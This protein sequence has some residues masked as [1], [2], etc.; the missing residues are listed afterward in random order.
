M[1]WLCTLKCAELGNR[2][3]LEESPTISS[4]VWELLIILSLIL[5][6]GFFSGAELAIISARRGQLRQRADEGHRAARLAL[7]LAENPN[8][9]L[10]TVQV[11]I[12]LVGTLT[13][14]FGGARVAGYLASWLRQ[15]NSPWI[16]HYAEPLS[17][18]VVVIALT[19]FTVLLG[20]LVPKR[21]AL[22]QA[23]LL[24]PLVAVPMD[25]LA[26][27]GR[28]AVWLLGFSTDVVLRLIGMHQHAEP[29][30]SVED[31]EHLIQTGTAGGV[32]EQAEQSVA[33]EALRLGERTVRDIMRPRIEIDGLDV[34]TPSEEVLGS[35]AM[36][37]YSRLPVYEG[38][39]D[40]IIGFVHIKDILRHAYLE[41]PINLRRAAHPVLFVPETLP[42]DRLLMLFK[43]HRTHLAIVLDEFGGCEG[44]V[45]L[46]DVLEELIGEIHDEHHPDLDQQL[47]RRD[48]GSWLVDGTYNIEDLLERLSL[49]A[50]LPSPRSFSTLAGLVLD[51][52]ERIPKVGD[53]CTWQGVELEVV[54]MD[55]P[56]IDRVLL[57]PP[58]GS[59]G[60]SS[61]DQPAAS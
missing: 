22:R 32:L 14:V 23:N 25:L 1:G 7:S 33:M 16:V 11:G 48:D 10:P 49:D 34:N 20:E 9:F 37:G 46:E 59:E 36:A 54:D 5:A 35:V 30:V 52:L 17:F 6:N 26:R 8:R 13:G 28:P 27:V 4:I 31:I 12:T 15:S 18:G 45:T 56:R 39:L 38:S 61:A 24:A 21:L 40:Q 19:Y 2:R 42:A 51:L 29:E 53:R 47:V 55:G 58:A 60:A 41:V 50:E 3:S 57:T 43:E 44:M